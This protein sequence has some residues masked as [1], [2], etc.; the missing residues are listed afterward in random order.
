M[1]ESTLWKL[2]RPPPPR[3]LAG[4]TQFHRGGSGFGVI[5]TTFSL[6][7]T[8]SLFDSTA[9]PIS[10]ISFQP[11]QVIGFCIFALHG[12]APERMNLSTPGPVLELLVGLPPLAR[13]VERVFK[14]EM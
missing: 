5:S 1:F 4:R 3:L 8:F 11:E 14:P 13:K 2:D 10:L 6:T 9:V 7:G 12:T